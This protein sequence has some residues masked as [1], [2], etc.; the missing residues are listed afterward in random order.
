MTFD[1]PATV[2][3]KSELRQIISAIEGGGLASVISVVPDSFWSDRIRLPRVSIAVLVRTEKYMW[4]KSW[5]ALICLEFV[6][7]YRVLLM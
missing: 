3:M 7:D 6:Q 5:N 2:Q 1:I 4:K